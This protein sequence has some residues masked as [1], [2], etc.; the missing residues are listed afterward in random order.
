MKTIK[1]IPAY[2]LKAVSKHHTYDF[3]YGDAS[4][5]YGYE[6]SNGRIREKYQRRNIFFNKHNI[7]RI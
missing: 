6:I 4:N 2:L 7:V 3:G 5:G 1:N